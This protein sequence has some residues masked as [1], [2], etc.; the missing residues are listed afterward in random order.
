MISG[1]KDL[2]QAT[3]IMGDKFGSGIISSRRSRIEE[4]SENNQDCC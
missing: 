3:V 1:S 2:V 4:T